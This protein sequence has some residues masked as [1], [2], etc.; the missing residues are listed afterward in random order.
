[1][2]EDLEAFREML[3]TVHNPCEGCTN[4]DRS[5]DIVGTSCYLCIRNP[6]DRRIDYYDKKT[7]VKRKVDFEND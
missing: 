5:K 4:E 6:V 7:I 3:N 1:M 2:D